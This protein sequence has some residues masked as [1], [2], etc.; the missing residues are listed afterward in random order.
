M[1]AGQLDD[2]PGTTTTNAIETVAAAVQAEFFGDGREFE[3]VE[4]W[5]DTIDMQGTPVFVRVHFGHR[6]IEEDPEDR[7]HYAGT[8]VVIDGE[9]TTAERGEPIRGDFR[10]P[11]WEEIPDITQLVGCGVEV[12]P[13]GEYTTRAVAGKEGQRHR[14]EAAEISKRAIQR[15]VELIEPSA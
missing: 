5:S 10:D 13:P 15:V 8:V 3:L 1:I 9:D 4:H 7:T 6:S 11:R 2:G 14:D 12:W